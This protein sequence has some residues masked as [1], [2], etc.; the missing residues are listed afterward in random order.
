MKPRRTPANLSGEQPEFLDLD[1]EL[2]QEAVAASRLIHY[3]AGTTLPVQYDAASAFFVVLQGRI[4]VYE[5]SENGREISLYRM[6]GGSVCVHTLM[7]LLGYPSLRARAVVEEDS[8]ILAVPSGYFQRLLVESNG[9]RRHVMTAMARCFSDVTQLIAQVSFKPLE[10]RLAQF[11]RQLSRHASVDTLKITHQA[12]ASEIGTTR[13]VVSRLLKAF[14]TAGYVKL[15]RGRI[16]IISPVECR[17]P[18]RSVSDPGR[19]L[20]QRLHNGAPERQH[21]GSKAPTTL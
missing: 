20:A 18:C 3:R 2:W 8:R 9:F 13:E 21:I 16:E 10:I 4:K 6:G 7:P 11:L 14:E 15:R 1:D 12:I 17:R 5:T 19:R